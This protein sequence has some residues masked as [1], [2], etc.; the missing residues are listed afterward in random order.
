MEIR[1]RLDPRAIFAMI[2]FLCLAFYLVFGLRPV[3]A[4]NYEI[5]ARVSIPKIN[6]VSD[7]TSLSLTEHRLETPDEIIGS[8]RR[9]KNKT[10]LIGHSSTVFKNLADV[11]IGDTV[12]YDEEIYV[13]YS[14]EILAREEVKMDGLLRGEEEPTLV[15]MTCAGE[16]LGNGDA[17]ER[18]IITAQ[19]E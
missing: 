15:I 5:I 14:K 9:A 2:Y 7:V 16:N 11:E 17:T 8:F 13:I 3:E 1:K 10:L 6:L 12:I 4:T 19:V 18:L